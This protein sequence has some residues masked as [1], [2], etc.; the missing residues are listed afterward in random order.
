MLYTREGWVFI[1][2]QYL[3]VGG[4]GLYRDNKQSPAGGNSNETCQVNCDS[5]LVSLYPT[6]RPYLLGVEDLE[7]AAVL[8]IRRVF[9]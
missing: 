8:Q 9:G 2:D 7:L 4:K 6:M 1:S 3:N 5:A